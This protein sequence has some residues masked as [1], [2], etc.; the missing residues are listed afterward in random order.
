MDA[1]S[2]G[3]LSVGNDLGLLVSHNF[4]PQQ[5]SCVGP[6]MEPITVWGHLLHQQPVSQL[7]SRKASLSPLK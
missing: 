1:T 3:H 6:S 5:H 2:A 4:I 7:P